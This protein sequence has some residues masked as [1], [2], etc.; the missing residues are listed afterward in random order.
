[1]TNVKRTLLHVMCIGLVLILI[2]GC[3][4]NSSGIKKIKD[5]SVSKEDQEKIDE[6]KGIEKEL[7]TRT[8]TVGYG[9][10][11]SI[12]LTV[13][14]GWGLDPYESDNH[15]DYSEIRAYHSD[16]PE[17]DLL[18]G[19]DDAEDKDYKYLSDKFGKKIDTLNADNV[20]SIKKQFEKSYGT[21]L[22]KQG[23]P[24]WLDVSFGNTTLNGQYYITVQGQ[25]KKK[26]KKH[27]GKGKYRY[28]TFY[29]GKMFKFEFTA[30]NPKIDGSVTAIFDSIMQTVTYEKQDD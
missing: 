24:R 8:G 30:K 10:G 2:T 13:P 26:S 7:N 23:Y 11:I 29:K 27:E 20:K 19:I 25:E 12:S 14:E 16:Y 5:I 28:I 9:D 3:Q 18:V 6:A 21:Y 1:M 4:K 17:Y 22:K 15:K